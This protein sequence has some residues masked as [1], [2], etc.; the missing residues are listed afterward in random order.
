MEGK[1]SFS[2]PEWADISGIHH[3]NNNNISRKKFIK[4]IVF[5]SSKEPPKDLIRRLLVVDAKQRISI[6]DALGHPFFQTMV[7]VVRKWQCL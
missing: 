6:D 3:N 7:S 4:N 1:Y 5:F 2:S